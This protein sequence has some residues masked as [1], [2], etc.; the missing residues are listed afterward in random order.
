MR[1][2]HVL[3]TYA[4]IA[5]DLLMPTFRIKEKHF[6]VDVRQNIT[7][8]PLNLTNLF[9]FLSYQKVVSLLKN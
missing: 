4:V 9:K 6:D 7:V 5:L 8:L 3:E 2:I 1:Y